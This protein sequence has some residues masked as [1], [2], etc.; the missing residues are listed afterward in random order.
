MKDVRLTSRQRRRLQAELRTVKDARVVK[1][2]LALLK[3]DHGAPLA[4]VAEEL[5]GNAA[6]RVQL[7][8]STQC[9]RRCRCASGS[10]GARATP[11]DIRSRAAVPG[12]EPGPTAGGA[13][14]RVGRLDDSAAARAPG[15][16]DGNPGV[17]RHAP[18]R[19]APV[20]LRLEAPAV[21]AAA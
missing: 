11:N 9:A 1:R 7:D 2:I 4:G 21:R 17:G 3:L 18:T 13:G 6:D 20:G 19:V 16:L 12:V 8:R 14:L 10:S 15:D 5:G